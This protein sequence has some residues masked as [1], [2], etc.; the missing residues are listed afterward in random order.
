M[1]KL[2]LKSNWNCQC[3]LLAALAVFATAISLNAYAQGTFVYGHFPITSPL[4]PNAPT[5]QWDSQGYRLWGDAA[6]GGQTYQLVINGQAAYTFYSGSQFSIIPSSLNAVV[7]ISATPPDMASL[8]VPLS[9]GQQIG[10]DALGYEWVSGSLGSTFTA[11]RDGG[12]I[13]QPPLT[14]GYFTGLA[15]AYVGLQFQTDG[16][17]YYGWA[18]VGAPAIGLNA[19]W[20][21][22]YAYATTPNTPIMAGQVPEPSAVALI[23]LGGAVALFRRNRK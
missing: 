9:A 5:Y 2:I 12:I 3:C 15:S 20:L 16:Q 13:G 8:A 22:D 19:G 18:R 14:I 17:T 4:D 21:Y 10:P 11:A 7:A 1:N 6:T 23:I